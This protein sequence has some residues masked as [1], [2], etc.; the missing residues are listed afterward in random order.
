LPEVVLEEVV[1]EAVD[2]DDDR[3]WEEDMWVE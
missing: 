2:S 1:A 3:L